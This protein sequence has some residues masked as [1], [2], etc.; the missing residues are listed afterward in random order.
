MIADYIL[1]AEIA[2]THYAVLLEMKKSFRPGDTK[3]FEQIWRTRP[4]VSYLK[5]LARDEEG[6]LP[7][8]VVFRHIVVAAEFGER[9]A[10]PP[11]KKSPIEPDERR[12][13]RGKAFHVFVGSRLP[14]EALVPESGA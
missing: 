9:L 1:F 12:M 7:Q 4:L 8:E 5:R 10:K 6:L 11:V 13:Y 14:L 3:P 2:G